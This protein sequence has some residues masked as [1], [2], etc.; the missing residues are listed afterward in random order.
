MRRIM[1]ILIV[2]MM[3]ATPVM[4][5][6]QSDN[7]GKQPHEGYCDNFGY[8]VPGMITN[9]TWMTPQ[10]IYSKGRMT[11]YGPQVM[12]ATAEYRGISYD[13]NGCIDGVALMSPIDIG[14]KVWIKIDEEWL[15]PFCSVDCARRGDMY[16]IVV[17]RQEVVEVSFEVTQM[18]GMAS[19]NEDYSYKV[20]EWYK[21]VE[22]LINVPPEV[23]NYLTPLTYKS[24]FLKYAT[25]TDK[26]QPA[27]LTVIEGSLWV[28]RYT[29]REWRN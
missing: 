6:S 12:R 22:V 9:D 27:I 13:E 3:S 24:H 23:A 1:L 29:G 15:G 7:R 10:P 14:K 26:W 2:I 8:F 18:L 25:Y 11:F 19:Y 5:C 28:E 17:Y 20:H 21:D 4:A 16:S